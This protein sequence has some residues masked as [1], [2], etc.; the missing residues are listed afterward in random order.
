MVRHRWNTTTS[1]VASAI[2]A[3]GVILTPL[4]FATSS[5]ASSVTLCK[6]VTLHEVSSAL[7]LKVT[8]VARQVNGSVTVC[9]Y[10]V[11]ANSQAVYVRSQTSDNTAGWKSDMKAAKSEQENPNADAKFAPYKA[12]STS[13]GS[14]TYGL[15]YSVVILKKSTELSVGAANTSLAKVEGLAKKVL[16]IV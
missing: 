15:T 12:F 14:Q 7:G 10:Q 1:V 9:W 4:S 2:V 16:G 3:V 13:V 8:K 5:S 6:A 11:G